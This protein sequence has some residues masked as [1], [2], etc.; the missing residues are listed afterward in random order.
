VNPGFAAC[1][2]QRGG[3]NCRGQNGGAPSEEHRIA[4]LRGLSNSTSAFSLNMYRELSKP[5][6]NVDNF[7]FS[8]YSIFSALSMTL[9]GTRG[10][11]KGE[12]KTGLGITERRFQVHRAM[13]IHNASMSTR[14]D[15]NTL[16]VA[17]AL[18]V[19]PGFN[20]KPSFATLLRDFYNSAVQE[21][22]PVNPEVPINQWVEERTGGEIEDFI[23]EGKITD[24]TVML[25][26][27]AIYF[28]GFWQSP[29]EATNTQTLPFHVSASQSVD[30]EMMSKT[31]D[32]KVKTSSVL[33]ARVLELPYSGGHY[34]LQIVLPDEGT[35]LEDVASRLTTEN[36][37]EM[38]NLDEIREKEHDVKIPKFG[39]DSSKSMKD[40]L[41]QLGIN[42]L[43]ERAN[44]RG[45]LTDRRARVNVED[46][47]HRALIK[48]D[49]EGTTAA[50][51]TG[52]FVSRYALVQHTRPIPFH[53]D[54]PFIFVIRDKTA[55]VNLFMG[56]Y[57]NPSGDNI[58]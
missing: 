20:Y 41:R 5:E 19:R 34:A 55:G 12:L 11:T 49:E 43:F 24:Q 23:E 18:Y 37:N 29:F 6:V 22:L 31:A 54:R 38:L 57:S 48:V 4:L 52:V 16:S 8:P 28:R 14:S 39:I 25:L 50:A 46:V 26:I 21:F 53:A 32:Y 42:S 35:M 3:R 30:A 45:M 10:R 33:G 15:N 2:G 51:A 58:V 17:N 7:V 40:S 1:R 47:V 36:I 13:N 9:L 27:N 56:R 44:F